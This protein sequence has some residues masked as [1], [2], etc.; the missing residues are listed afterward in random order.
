MKISVDWWWAGADDFDLCRCLYAYLHPRT[1]EL[2]Y[3]GKADRQSVRQRMNGRHKDGVYEYLQR[4]YRLTK[5]RPLIGDLRL[6][7]DQRFSSALLADVESLLINR[8]APSCNVSCIRSRIERPGL[9]VVC[10]GDWWPL[11]RRTFRDN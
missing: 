3:L 6:D 11:D 1:D 4:E 5:L 10:R 2:L 7:E 9:I 8:I